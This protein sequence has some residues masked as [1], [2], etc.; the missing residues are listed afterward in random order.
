MTDKDLIAIGYI[1]VITGIPFKEVKECIQGLYSER[2]GGSDAET[3]YQVEK[4]VKAIGK[5]PTTL[6][7]LGLFLLGEMIQPSTTQGV[8]DMINLMEN[9]Q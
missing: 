7:E 5:L 9:P 8:M 4:Y 3:I 1:T 6:E 2:S